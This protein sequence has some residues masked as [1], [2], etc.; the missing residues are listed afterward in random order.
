[1][2][3]EIGDVALK[4]EAQGCWQATWSEEKSLEESIP[5]AL[6]RGPTLPTLQTPGL[7]ICRE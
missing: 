6:Q 1:M 2:E 3:A 5:Q 7:Q 4:H